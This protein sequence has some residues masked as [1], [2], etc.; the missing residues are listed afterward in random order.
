[1]PEKYQPSGVC[2]ISAFLLT[3]FVTAVFSLVVGVLYSL[4]IWY[5]PIVYFSI[6]GTIGW[7]YL[8][9]IGPGQ[10][11]RNG[12]I[13]SPMAAGLAGFLGVLPGYYF[14]WVVWA[15]LV[16]NMGEAITFGGRR[17]FSI[18][19][20]TLHLDELLQIAT[21]PAGL[22]EKIREV[23]E[24]GLWSVGKSG[25]PVHGPA[26]GAVWAVEFLIIVGLTAYLYA[27]RARRPYSEER[28]RWFPVVKLPK[29]LL[30]PDDLTFHERL[31]SSG[32]ITQIVEAT[33]LDDPKTGDY[34][35]LVVYYSPEERE[36]YLDV[37]V[38]VLNK[39]KSHDTTKLIEALK[40]RPDQAKKLVEKFS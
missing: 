7:G 30:Y 35:S 40:I 25:T 23:N 1:M 37:E 11:I 18:S 36:A 19:K 28:G 24:Y 4:A 9:S 15:D 6:L 2:P 20:S 14:S 8:V 16:N 27:K 34:L 26:L 12:H 10:T 29:F 5:V 22:V 3:L 32:D 38:G 33:T 21:D 39:K 31:L 17:G 13:R